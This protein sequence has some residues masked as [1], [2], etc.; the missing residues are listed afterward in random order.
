M[1]PSENGEPNKVAP[2][3][4]TFINARIAL[5][6]NQVIVFIEANVNDSVVV[7]VNAISEQRIKLVS[8]RVG[9]ASYSSFASHVKIMRPLLSVVKKLI[10]SLAMIE[11]MVK[12][13]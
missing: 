3:S 5:N 13:L 6:L 1:A 4:P 7:N 9:Y 11:V 2:A 12:S 10:R 8:L